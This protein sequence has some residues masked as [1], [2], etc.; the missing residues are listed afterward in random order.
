VLIYEN[1][2]LNNNSA[3]TVKDLSKA[4]VLNNKFNDNIVDVSA[5][6]KKQIFGGGSVYLKSKKIKLKKDKWS[7][8]LDIGTNEMQYIEDIFHLN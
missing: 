7:D 5:Y 6:K 4:Y 8:F 2:F 1:N 3:I